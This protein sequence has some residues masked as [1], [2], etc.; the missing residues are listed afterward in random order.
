MEKEKIRGIITNIYL[1]CRQDS[2]QQ[3]IFTLRDEDS[4]QGVYVKCK[5]D[6]DY[7]MS[8][9]GSGQLLFVEQIVRHGYYVECEGIVSSVEG[10]LEAGED[11]EE[12][13]NMPIM[14]CTNVTRLDY[15]LYHYREF[16]VNGKGVEHFIVLTENIF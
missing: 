2:S 11:I 16:K 6:T 14:E 1:L 13:G 8:E 10:L 7:R 15:K 5:T 12:I 3:S 9:F 4:L